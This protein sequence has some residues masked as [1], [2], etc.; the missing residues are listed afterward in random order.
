MN[1]NR[2]TSTIPLFSPEAEAKRRIVYV[3]TSDMALN[4]LERSLR[5]KY[6]D[7]KRK[8][9]ATNK[10]KMLATNSNLAFLKDQ[11]KQ[12][13]VEVSCQ[14]KFPFSQLAQKGGFIQKDLREL[15]TAEQRRKIAGVAGNV[16]SIGVLGQGHNTPFSQLLFEFDCAKMT[17]EYMS[18]NP[19]L[20]VAAALAF[21]NQNTQ[22]V[23]PALGVWESGT[24]FGVCS[25]TD[26]RDDLQKL[27]ERITG[28]TFEELCPGL[29]QASI[30]RR[31]KVVEKLKSQGVFNFDTADKWYSC[32]TDI[33]EQI[34]TWGAGLCAEVLHNGV[35]LGNTN[36][37]RSFVLAH[38]LVGLY[39]MRD[40]A[41]NFLVFPGTP[42]IVDAED[43][44]NR[45]A[46]F[47]ASVLPQSSAYFLFAPNNAIKEAIAA[48]TKPDTSV[49]A[50]LMNAT[51]RTIE[52]INLRLH[53]GEAQSGVYQS[54][55]NGNYQFKL[56]GEEIFSIPGDY[57]C[58][59]NLKLQITISENL[60]HKSPGS[61]DGKLVVCANKDMHNSWPQAVFSEQ[62]L[63]EKKRPNVYMG[64]PSLVQTQAQLSQQKSESLSI[65]AQ[66]TANRKKAIVEGKEISSDF[67]DNV[68]LAHEHFENTGTMYTGDLKQSSSSSEAASSSSSSSLAPAEDD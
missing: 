1:M 26:V 30:L 34:E 3:L 47:K 44:K 64:T 17:A 2:G 60:F 43:P 11:I 68:R 52:S 31:K 45:K 23:S 41:Q 10:M 53:S 56:D 61:F 54:D 8:E 67:D 46:T 33:D 29:E 4:R 38:S 21:H 5:G 63:I 65:M 27:C 6:D 28:H 16:T 22:T 14:V 57:N 25:E 7:T 9:S 42:D 32:G 55:G 48:L 20:P 37:G 50:R 19:S 58:V 18:K 40:T 13:Q 62:L 51:F 15:M 39:L 35:V 59:F 36:E 66:V 24:F 12:Q 49:H